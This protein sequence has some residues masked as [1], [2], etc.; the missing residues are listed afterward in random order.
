MSETDFDL[1][2]VL[3][4]HY[5][6][7][8][9]TWDA[10]IARLPGIRCIAPNLRGFGGSR[11]EDGLYRLSD[12]VRDVRQ[13]LAESGAR[14]FVLVG[15][16]M[17]GKIAMA[18][19]ADGLTGVEALVL[20]APSPPTP[21]PISDEVRARLA[22]TLE[23]SAGGD[24]VSGATARALS[25]DAFERAVSDVQRSEP[26]AW[27][28][29]LEAGSRQDISVAVRRVAVQTLLLSGDRDQ[30]IPTDVIRREVLTCLPS[31]TLSI[32][33]GAGH[34]LPLEA[35]AAVANAI[36]T[37]VRQR[38]ARRGADG[39]GPSGGIAAQALL[40]RYRLG[41]VAELLNSDAVTEATRRAVVARVQ[42]PLAGGPR[43][44]TQ[45]Q[46]E[47]LQSLC[48]RLVPQPSGDVQVDIARRVD[49][50]LAHGLGNGWRYFEMPSDGDAYR[51]SL[52][53]LDEM[54]RGTFAQQF[55]RLTGEQQDRILLHAQ[56]NEVEVG[57]WAR[58]SPARFIEE[59]LVESC[60]I[61]YSHPAVQEKIGYAGMADA[62]GWGLI[63]LNQ[64]DPLEPLESEDD[65]A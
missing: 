51:G 63:G 47:T 26:A 34:L 64:R 54:A 23:R 9:R 62:K 27:L 38:L 19:L 32:I 61:Y 10:V 40:G 3:L 4:H 53:A 14:S 5:G 12:Y 30:N 6:G 36:K 17:G 57:P 55:S 31:A 58:V 18:A 8:A 20:L 45:D 7:S 15:H 52:L 13:V 44:F 25:P 28:A 37:V 56:Y 43:F 11:A 49:E 59:I 21:E 29:W 46:L 24:V 35:P 65:R 48:A 2:V 50:R 16:S 42:P 1:A 60:E 39:L 22:R 41:F 33:P